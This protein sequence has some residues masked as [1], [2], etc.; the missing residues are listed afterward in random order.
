[1]E[2]QVLSGK[3]FYGKYTN[4]KSDIAAK[5]FW[6]KEVKVGNIAAK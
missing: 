5:S 6:S 4:L 1:M 2:L 3:A